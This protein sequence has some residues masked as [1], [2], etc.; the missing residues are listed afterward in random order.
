MLHMQVFRWPEQVLHSTATRFAQPVR[1]LCYSPPGSTLAAGGDDGDIKLVDVAGSQVSSPSGK[2]FGCLMIT[3]DVARH[4][5]ADIVCSAS[6][7]ALPH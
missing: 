4:V 5:G 1:A 2:K 6:H 3:F 7:I